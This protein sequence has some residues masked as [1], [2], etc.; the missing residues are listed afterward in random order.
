MVL[1][2]SHFSFLGCLH[3][4]SASFTLCP[5]R[6]SKV[7]TAE[8]PERGTKRVFIQLTAQC[9]QSA[10]WPVVNA[11]S[12]SSPPRGG[13]HSAASLACLQPKATRVRRSS[14]LESAELRNFLKC[15]ISLCESL[16]KREQEVFLF[17]TAGGGG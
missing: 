1:K 17:F 14:P 6:R 16:F 10:D 5:V 8:G 3:L 7:K 2:W 9:L 11:T 13:L 12:S 15:E 4:L